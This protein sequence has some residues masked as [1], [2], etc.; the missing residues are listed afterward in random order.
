MLLSSFFNLNFFSLGAFLT[1]TA[2]SSASRPPTYEIRR[3]SAKLPIDGA[4]L[5]EAWS[6][7][8]LL[9]SLKL[10]WDQGESQSTEARFLWD[11]T[12]LY[13]AFRVWDKDIVTWTD[14]KHE[15]KLAVVDHDRVEMFFAPSEDLKEY[16]CLEVDPNGLVLDYKAHHYRNF[17]YSWSL[18]GLRVATSIQENGYIVE[19]AIPL[20]EMKRLGFPLSTSKSGFS[21]RVGVYRADFSLAKP[22]TLKMLWQTWVD[23]QVAQPDFHVPSSFGIFEFVNRESR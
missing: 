12:Y 11:A 9:P 4:L 2:M 6:G 14:P 13:A 10:P 1:L 22:G 23:P 3:T 17:D 8:P 20:R 7:A 18:E 19:L 21:W 15:G 5:D 16:Y